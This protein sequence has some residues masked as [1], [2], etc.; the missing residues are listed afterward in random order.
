MSITRAQAQKWLTIT[1]S[2]SP[3]PW[4]AM[5]ENFS[6]HLIST[7]PGDDGPRICS[8]DGLDM[9]TEQMDARFIAT[10]R[11]AMPLL[12]AE[13]FWVPLTKSQPLPVHGQLVLLAMRGRKE[14]VFIKFEYYQ[15]S[16]YWDGH[17]P[18]DITHWRALPSL[19]TPS[20]PTPQN[21]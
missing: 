19:P 12:L 14:P 20:L 9:E 21:S 15:G 5:M 6:L 7:E 18:K 13:P 2:A 4:K 3:G 11:E 10:A 8:M 1:D 16:P 17:N